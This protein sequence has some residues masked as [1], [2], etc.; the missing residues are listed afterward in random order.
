MRILESKLKQP[1]IPE[2]MN[3]LLFL[4]VCLSFLLFLAALQANMKVYSLSNM[5][6]KLYLCFI[7]VYALFQQGTILIISGKWCK[8]KNLG[9]QG[10][11]VIADRVENLNSGIVYEKE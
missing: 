10:N 1:F 9:V 5:K 11:V 3:G 2:Y 6:E 4:L 8:G 7:T